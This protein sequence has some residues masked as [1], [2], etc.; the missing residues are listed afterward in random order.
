VI[1]FLITVKTLFNAYHLPG[2]GVVWKNL[3][4]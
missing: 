1:E 4:V 3:E 2:W